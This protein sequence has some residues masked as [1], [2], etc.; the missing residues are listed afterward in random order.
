MKWYYRYDEAPTLKNIL[1]YFESDCRTLEKS[2]IFEIPN[3]SLYF[4]KSEEYEKFS[5]YNKK[6]ILKQI[7]NNI[8]NESR[9]PLINLSG[10]DIT[11]FQQIRNL[12]LY[13]TRK[14]ILNIT[15]KLTYDKTTHTTHTN[16]SA[17]NDDNAKKYF[18]YSNL[19]IIYQCYAQKYYNKCLHYNPELKELPSN[20]SDQNGQSGQNGGYKRKY[21]KYKQ[22]YL[23]LKST[24]I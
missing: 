10:I 8:I 7:I 19:P 24:I 11:H 3:N 5:D 1:E 12:T 6:E 2:V 16:I 9:E 15:A 20:T 14:D 23:S 13:K 4:K 21:L 22:K 17:Y 18:V